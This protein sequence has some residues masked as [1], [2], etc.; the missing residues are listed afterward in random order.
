L[1]LR[2]LTPINIAIYGY[3]LGSYICVNSGFLNGTVLEVIDGQQ[4]FSTLLLLLTALYEKLSAL[5]SQMELEDKTDLS[6]LSLRQKSLDIISLSHQ[7][8]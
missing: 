5:E 8:F 6:N 4:R 2:P 3:F 1:R 7:T